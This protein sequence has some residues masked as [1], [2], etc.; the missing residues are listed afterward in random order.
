LIAKAKAL[1]YLEAK[2]RP[3]PRVT[4]M[5]ESGFTGLPGTGL[6]RKQRWIQIEVQGSRS[7]SLPLNLC[8]FHPGTTTKLA[9]DRM[10]AGSYF[11]A[12]G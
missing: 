12:N 2:Q 8:W 5:C 4:A 9:I 7:I 1:A 11:V 3:V 6:V 10:N